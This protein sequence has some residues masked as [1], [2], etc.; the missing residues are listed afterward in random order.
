M[1]RVHVYVQC[2]RSSEVMLQLSKLESTPFA[3]HGV[4]PS[5]VKLI[6]DTLRIIAGIE[7]CW[8]IES[9]RLES[10]RFV[11]LV[12]EPSNVKS[13]CD[14]RITWTFLV[15]K[16]WNREEN[17]ENNNNRNVEIQKN[18]MKF[19]SGYLTLIE[20]SYTTTTYFSMRK[21]ARA[22]AMFIF[23]SLVE[24]NFQLSFSPLC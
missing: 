24:S 3:C 21:A 13:I 1:Y 9:I 11:C 2:D 10:T 23:H 16:A 17:T 18:N 5:N 7:Q 6:C 22:I 4:E 15:L 20:R 14:K 12:V 19:P 8:Q